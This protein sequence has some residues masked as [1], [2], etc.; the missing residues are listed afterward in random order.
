MRVQYGIT[1]R[2][3]AL[4]VVETTN[5]GHA[6]TGT[7]T[8][9]TVR[10]LSVTAAMRFATTLMAS[11]HNQSRRPILIPAMVDFGWPRSYFDPSAVG[12]DV[13]KS[14]GTVT[15]AGANRPPAASPPGN[16]AYSSIAICDTGGSPV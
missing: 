6:R 10:S 14:P 16:G 1:T 5:P 9:S 15:L 8:H 4:I 13:A 11:S 7:S 2:H 12:S 3:N